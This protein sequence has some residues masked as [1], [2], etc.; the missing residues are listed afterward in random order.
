VVRPGR[1]RYNHSRVAR[2]RA[3][4][5]L[6]EV[7]TV[8]REL[9]PLLVGRRLGTISVSKCALRR[10][11][12]DDWERPLA[13]R[14]VVEVRRR[15]KW[16]VVALD[17]ALHLV[18]HLGMTGRL[19]VDPA[20]VPLPEHTHLIIAVGDGLELRFRDVR[21]FGS[22]TL[23]DGA[24]TLARF[25]EESSLGP[26]PFDC[27]PADWRAKLSRT[28]R[29]LKAVLLDQRVVAGVGNIYADESLFEARLHPARK[30]N[31]L[32]GAEAERLRRAV[33]TVLRRA[34]ERRGSTI[35]DYVGASGLR[36]S[37]QDEFR[38]YGRTGDPCRRCR[39]PIRRERLA[40]RSTH[41]CPRC[42]QEER[43]VSGEWRVVRRPL[44][45]NHSRL[46]NPC[47][48]GPSST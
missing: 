40:G 21:R 32:T 43:V 15:G 18:I 10:P 16:I 39:T 36:G 25:F 24:E 19:T 14:R 31:A 12:R 46:T 28:A 1:S 5:E 8:V 9:R 47:P 44:T 23:I 34:I 7:E 38:A 35:R 2:E 33:A 3:V 45:T 29:P 17:R 48:T 6:P 30:G 26:E 4:P 22:A 42:Q 11:W 20:A 41:Y 37:Y 13:G 27:D